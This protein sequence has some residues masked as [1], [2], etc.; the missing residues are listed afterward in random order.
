MLSPSAASENVVAYCAGLRGALSVSLYV[1]H[2][3]RPPPPGHVYHSVCFTRCSALVSVYSDLSTQ[4]MHAARRPTARPLYRGRCISYNIAIWNATIYR[5]A[6]WATIWSL[7]D[8]RHALTNT[9]Q[10]AHLIMR[11]DCCKTSEQPGS[12]GSSQPIVSRYWTETRKPNLRKHHR[13]LLVALAGG[14]ANTIL[15]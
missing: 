9:W 15:T 6:C 7:V 4:T 8:L 2:Q 5:L 13:A 14:V 11:S 1:K 3:T 12:R 10:F